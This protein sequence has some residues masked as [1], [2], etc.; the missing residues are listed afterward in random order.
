M[1]R[2]HPRAVWMLFFAGSVPTLSSIG[3]LMLVALLFFAETGAGASSTGQSFGDLFVPYLDELAWV[4]LISLIIKYVWA[5]LSWMFYKYELRED[6]FRKEHGIIWKK[7]VSIPY[8]RIQNVDIHRGIVARLLGLSDIQV[9][10]A[11]GI[12]MGSYGAFSEGRLP[13]I[14]KE[15]AEVIRDELIKRARSGSTQAPV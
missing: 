14:G 11:G 1:K 2:L 6:G 10:T 4:V 8:S 5:Y 7:Y 12:T 13:G 3:T 15:E 9:Q